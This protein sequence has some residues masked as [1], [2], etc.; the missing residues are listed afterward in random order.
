VKRGTRWLILLVVLLFA[1]SML[2]SLLFLNRGPAT[3]RL[4]LS[5][6]KI[7]VVEIRGMILDVKD[8]L[9][10]IKTLREDQAIKAMLVRIESPGGAVGPSQEI[11][12]ELLRTAKHKPVVASLGGIAASGGYY[13][14]CAANHIVANPGTLT[15]SIGVI[16]RFGNLRSLFDKVGYEMIT[17]KSGEFKDIGNPSR[18][19]TPEEEA[20]VQAMIDSVHQQFI[21]DVAAGRRLAEKDVQAIADG[22][23]LTGEAARQ[24]GLVDEL[25]NFQDAVN[26]AARL[27]AIQVEPE[28]VYPEK[29]KRSLVDYLFGT[30]VMQQVR[31]ILA[32][33]WQP[34]RYQAPF[35]LSP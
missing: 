28:L 33:P 2:G 29:K 1:L 9:E 16:V 10:E 7:G 34:L 26:T 30:E 13:I 8:T 3:A 19:M 6:G 25:G 22:R 35:P 27:G 11:Y 12:Q 21:R 23:V 17:L 31:M 15:G 20:L 32:E 24:L 5:S 14:A 4:S 18:K